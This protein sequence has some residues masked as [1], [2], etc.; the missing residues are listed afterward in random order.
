MKT[1]KDEELMIAKK[2]ITSSLME[3]YDYISALSSLNYYKEFNEEE[4]LEARIKLFNNVSIEDLKKVFKKIKAD[5]IYFVE[6]NDNNE[7]D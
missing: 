4:D 7:E 2:D 1:I 5:C 3:N 6:G